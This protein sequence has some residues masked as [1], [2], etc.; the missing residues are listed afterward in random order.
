MAGGVSTPALVIA[1]GEA[2]GL[3]QLAAGYLPPQTVEAQV[4]QVQA[5]GVPFG[6]NVFVAETM[7]PAREAEAVERYRRRLEPLA[8]HLD[9]ALPEP[10]WAD[11]DH[12]REKLDLL[13][14]LA[15]PV[16]SFTFGCPDPVDIQRL[17]DAGS[18]VVV[19]VTSAAEAQAAAAAGADALCVQGFE[20]GGHR[21]T[22]DRRA[23]PESA[24]LLAL[25]HETQKVCDLPLIGAGGIMTS[26]QAAGALEAGAVAIQA[27]SAFLLVDEAGTRPA[28]R[29]ALREPDRESVLT[30]AFS[31]RVGRGLANTWTATFPDAPPT[32]PVVDQLTKPLRARAGALEDPEHL[33]LWAG[34]GWREARVGTA[35]EVVQR[36]DPALGRR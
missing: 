4:R 9:A 3:G 23:V 2:G 7:D 25:L 13:A 5:S 19:T 34:T 6:V 15:P 22:W 27:G 16:V 24:G 33:N 20:A 26:A 14:R 21:G 11:T 36:L 30:R 18:A 1:V 28:H 35:A 32:F 17:R 10:D 31:G 29:R 12:Y 8:E